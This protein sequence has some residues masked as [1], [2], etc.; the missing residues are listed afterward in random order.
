MYPLVPVAYLAFA[1]FVH[2]IRLP[3]TDS[4][5]L[6][7]ACRVGDICLDATSFPFFCKPGPFAGRGDTALFDKRPRP[8]KLDE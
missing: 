3:D 1:Y 8:K 4:L 7:C 2:D 6:L 5:A